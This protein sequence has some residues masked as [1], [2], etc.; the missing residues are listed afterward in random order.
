MRYHAKFNLDL[1]GIHFDLTGNTQELAAEV[2]KHVEA[3]RTML[4][5][6]VRNNSRIVPPQFES[7]APARE[8]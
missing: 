6:L 2:D 3:F 8:L 5:E 4:T 1:Q 7:A